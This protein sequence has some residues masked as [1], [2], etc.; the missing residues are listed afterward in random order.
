VLW[1]IAA[2]V[3]TGPMAFFVAAVVDLLAFTLGSL[4]QRYAR[5]RGSRWRS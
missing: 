4:R 5:R 3:V 2:R 1:R